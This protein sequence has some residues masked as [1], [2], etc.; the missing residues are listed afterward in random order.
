MRP[1]VDREMAPLFYCSETS[2]SYQEII[3][4]RRYQFLH[5]FEMVWQ[6]FQ[7]LA[8]LKIDP[9]CV[10]RITRLVDSEKCPLFLG[11]LLASDKMS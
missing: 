5:F 9:D 10:I 2:F 8:S 4:L 6:L 7:G 1:Q 3:F 11:H